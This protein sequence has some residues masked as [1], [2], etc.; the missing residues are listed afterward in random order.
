MVSLMSIVD[1]F[2]AWKK[3]KI[4]SNLIM[5]DEKNQNC[6]RKVLKLVDGVKKLH[7]C[8]LVS[9]YIWR[10]N[11]NKIKFENS[12][13]HDNFLAS[14]FQRAIHTR[15]Y[16]DIKSLASVFWYLEHSLTFFTFKIGKSIYVQPYIFI[17]TFKYTFR[18]SMIN[19][20]KKVCCI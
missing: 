13:N 6:I 12:K 15:C 5:N 9:E 20:R 2:E 8:A 11:L 3:G 18:H 7:I 17:T 19:P 16:Y 1:Y 14:E 10:K 4:F